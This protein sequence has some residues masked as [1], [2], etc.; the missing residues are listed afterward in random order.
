MSYKVKGTHN[1]HFELFD[2]NGN[3]LGKLD[4]RNFIS[5]NADITLSNGDIYHVA[6]KGMFGTT[7]EIEHNDNVIGTVTFNWKGQI[8][9][10]FTDTRNYVF[11]GSG[12]WHHHYI[13]LDEAGNELAI[14]HP[15]FEWSKLSH[16]YEIELHPEHKDKVNDVFLPL[17]LTYCANLAISMGSAGV[18]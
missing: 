12:F 11:K 9:I 4:Y 8:I 3:S 2:E 1:R 6:H 5:A 14:I 18:V 15:D 17:I 7:I 13:L 10:S 16:T